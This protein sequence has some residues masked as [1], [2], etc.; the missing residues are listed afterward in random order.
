MKKSLKH[1]C[2]SLFDISMPVFIILGI[3]IVL[4][5]GVAILSRIGNLSV[6]IY[7]TLYPYASGAS[8]LCMFSAFLYSYVKNK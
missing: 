5:Q 7:K 4:V 1:L 3:L 6:W 2:S 8:S